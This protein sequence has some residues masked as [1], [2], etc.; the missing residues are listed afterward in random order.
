MRST[1]GLLAV[2]VALAACA[3]PGPRPGVERARDVIAGFEEANPAVAE[4]LDR[5]A[6]WAVFSDAE[7]LAHGCSHAGLLF[8]RD[9]GTRPCRLRCETRPNAPA[10]V[11]SHML[12]IL[13]EGSDLEQLARRE[14]ELEDAA[15]LSPP[16]T[17]VGDPDRA[18]RWIVATSRVSALHATAP[19]IQVL[20]LVRD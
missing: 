16:A 8:T 3:A 5:A 10:G 9:G 1:L 15:W 18:T 19:P 11:T 20:E 4:L 14:L 2:A 6:A 7:D 17:P 13:L 12:V